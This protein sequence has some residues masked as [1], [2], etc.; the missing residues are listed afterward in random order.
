MR[1]DPSGAGELALIR[2]TIDYRLSGLGWL[3][4]RVRGTLEAEEG[5]I[6]D[7]GIRVSI[8]Y[9]DFRAPVRKPS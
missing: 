6:P 4:Q 9:R 3:P 8:T 1:A 7:D 5:L 2:K